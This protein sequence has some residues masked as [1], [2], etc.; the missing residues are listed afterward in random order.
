VAT[1]GRAQRDDHEKRRV[2]EISL[3]QRDGL[4]DQALAKSESIGDYAHVVERDVGAVY[5]A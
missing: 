5:L 1:S 4:G 3:R 2:D